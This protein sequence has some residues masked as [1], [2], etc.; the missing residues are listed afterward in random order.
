MAKITI[1]P[2]I[3]PDRKRPDGTY[4]I[5]MRITCNRKSRYLQTSEIA[6]S[7]QLTKSLAIKDPE[8]Q[9]RL[10]TLE[11]KM[12]SAVADLDMFTL[13]KMDIDEIVSYM[14]KR[15]LGDFH[16]EFCKFWEE[17]I[18]DKPEGTRGYYMIALHSL[19]RFIGTDTIDISRITSRFMREYEEWLV[20]KYGK[21]ARA[22]TM[23]TAAVK[24]VH[25]LARKKYNNDELGETLIRNPFE[26][27]TPPESKP[28]EKN[29]KLD[30][31]VIQGMINMRQQLTGLERRAVDAFLLSFGMMGMNAPDI[32]SCKPPKKDI[33]I[34]NRQ[35]TRGQRPDKAEMHVLIDEHI[36]P[37]YEEYAEDDGIHAFI[38]HRFYCNFKQ[39]NRALSFGLRKY[40]GRM[41]IPDLDFYCARHTWGTLARR[42]G[43][44]KAT[45]NE[46]L[47]H[48]GEFRITDIYAERN[49]ALAWEANKKVLDLFQWQ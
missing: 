31:S 23:Y 3:R 42:L 43:I 5:L 36:R 19:Q 8:L 6:N 1:A 34:Y 38:F 20:K 47:V 32:L 18:S 17:A 30:V 39:F 15:I 41:S 4:T 29:R 11:A 45:V 49:W 28:A 35:K 22:V 46:A 13:E 33:I 12:R 40:R 37:L 21:G 24:H 9:L 2:Y 16:L 48:V 7:A 10:L 14:N 26:L 25:S 27:Y 44:E